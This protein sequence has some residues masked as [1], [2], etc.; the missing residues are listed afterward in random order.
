MIFEGTFKNYNNTKTY[1][2]KIGDSGATKEI[3]GNEPTKT[4]IDQVW[5]GPDPVT[6]TSD[7][8]D[9]FKN[10]Y[11]R[12][13]TIN[14]VSNYN[15]AKDIT[16]TNYTDIPVII[17]QTSK[18]GIFIFKG[19]VEPL[20]F[21]MP[22]NNTWNEFSVNCVDLLGIAEYIKFDWESA[23]PNTPRA[24]ISSILG[25]LGFG[26]S[27]EWSVE[28]DQTT[29]TYIDPAVFKGETP[30]D[31]WS[32]LEVLEEIGK[33][34]GLWFRQDGQVCK[35]SNI[36]CDRESTKTVK[37]SIEIGS[38]GSDVQLSL[39]EAY[40]QVNMQC[41]V[42]T[43]PDTFINPFD[44]SMLLPKFDTLYNYMDEVVCPGEGKTAFN[45]FK[46]FLNNRNNF[47][48]YDVAQKYK[49]YADVYTNEMFDFGDTNYASWSSV[50]N[51]LY[52]L[53]NH[54]GKAGFFGFGRS[55]NINDPKNTESIHSVDLTQYFVINID[56]QERTDPT[57]MDSQ[58][59][60]NIPIATINVPNTNL[61]PIGPDVTN[62]LIISGKILL[63]PPVPKTGKYPAAS[64]NNYYVDN[65]AKWDGQ[66]TNW[67]I[68][69]K[70]TVQDCLNEWDYSGGTLWHRT[71]PDDT[72]GDGA[73]YQHIFSRGD[74][75][76]NLIGPITNNKLKKYQFKYSSH[77][78]EYDD[79]NKVSILACRLKVGNKYCVERIDINKPD[80]YEW[81]DQN[82]LPTVNG[83]TIDYFTIGINP[84]IDDYL[85]GTSFSIADT[86][87]LEDRLSTA[88][89][90][91]PIKYSDYL[92]GNIEFE[93]LGPCNTT[94]QDN[95]T[96]EHGWAW[97]QHTIFRATD[98]QLLEHVSSIFISNFKINLETNYKGS[99]VGND[100]VYSSSSNNTYI[101]NYDYECELHTALT[102]EE[103]TE[104][105]IDYKTSIN[106]IMT[107]ENNNLIPFTGFDYID[108]DGNT[109]T[110]TK[111]EEA[112]VYEQYNW[113][114]KIR[115]IVQF[116]VPI[117]N[118]KDSI[119][120]YD[121]VY[122]SNWKLNN[123]Y[124]NIARN[125][126]LK[127]DTDTI[128]MIEK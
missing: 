5:F 55:E 95:Y 4:N 128:T 64:Y 122:G 90:C 127:Y 100:L 13:C 32:S 52:W 53:Y 101:Q 43:V 67:Y 120:D 80:T 84:K 17:K 98:V 18:N 39:S 110:G 62:Y 31:K 44:D 81:R 72:N 30:E 68:K 89:T 91:I 57:V 82:E 21:N 103:A 94:W 41:N 27:I 113:H 77:H 79:V 126:D 69:A 6:I 118:P 63:Q 36:L 47:V 87:Q 114:N 7:T 66:N 76:N 61:A 124:T 23:D 33:I 26:N 24:F 97:W 104:M 34:Y 109:N 11:V 119:L 59:Q 58:I 92:S 50:D 37:S 125:I 123:T 96:V 2:V 19:Y 25:N 14:L 99:D 38:M 115:E 116:D 86:R 74:S 20:S 105:G 9:T 28:N 12:G 102:P 42:T 75:Y 3:G 83:V 22:Y 112:R 93:I 56:G 106:A 10:V 1:Y 49:H 108:M 45:A 60:A 15:I 73:Y 16:A 48:M 117:S 8:S 121:C 85:I 54:P 70:N 51:C 40:N 88:G 29:N 78:Q 46:E 71:V 107:K 65:I 111:L 35:I